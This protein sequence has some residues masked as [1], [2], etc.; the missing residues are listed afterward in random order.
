MQGKIVLL[1]GQVDFAGELQARL[2]I[3]F[4]HISIDHLRGADVL[5]KSRIESGEFSW[6][7]MRLSFYEGCHRSLPALSR[8]SNHLIVEQIFE[9]SDWMNRLPRLLAQRTSAF[10]T[11]TKRAT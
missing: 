1:N 6:R 5:P 2:D 9:T 8:A 4:W 7:D 10:D 11:M 3:P